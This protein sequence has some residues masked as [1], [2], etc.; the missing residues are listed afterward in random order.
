MQRALGTTLLIVGC[1]ADPGPGGP[2]A[3]QSVS[4]ADARWVTVLGSDLAL[5][6]PMLAQ[7]IQERRGRVRAE[8]GSALVWV[9]LGMVYEANFLPALALSCYEEAVRLEPGEPRSWYR[10][11]IV[12]W[13]RGEVSGA[14]DAARRA[15]DLA[16]SFAPA[17]WRLGLFEYES[18]DFAAARGDFR[19]ATEIDPNDAVGWLGLGQCALEEGQLEEAIQQLKKVLLVRSGDR[20]AVSLLASALR[21]GGEIDQAESL[22]R[23]AFG[24][25]DSS[26]ESNARTTAEPGGLLSW[27]DPW[28]AEMTRRTVRSSSRMQTEGVLLTV[29]GEAQ[30]ALGVLEWVVSQRSDDLGAVLALGQAYRGAGQLE[31]ALT[32]FERCLAIQPRHSDALL[33]KSSVLDEMGRGDEALRTIDEVIALDPMHGRA[34][35]FK[36][37][38]LQHRRDA[39]GAIAAYRRS[40]ELDGRNAHAALAIG[41][42]HLGEK[43]WADAKSSLIEAER[44]FPNSAEILC[45]LAKAE[46]ELGGLDAAE[47]HLAQAAQAPLDGDPKRFSAMLA[48]VKRELQERKAARASSKG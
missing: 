15:R 3:P 33:R 39:A 5:L 16:P 26:A 4:T 34:H 8:P 18:G 42:V 47:D 21:R 11:G 38:F 20:F 35:Y 19:R 24:R 44:R 10:L 9:E 41:M 25:E 40:L 22:L 1:G 46:L 14:L 32:A 12:R 7:E 31:K 36:G 6:D 28:S 13:A 48:Q 2:P 43:Q 27:P 30:Q 29:G 23:A 45:A 37:I 17:H